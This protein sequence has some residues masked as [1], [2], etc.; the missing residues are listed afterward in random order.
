MSKAFFYYFPKLFFIDLFFFK[1]FTKE[2]AEQWRGL[3]QDSGDPIEFGKKAIRFYKKH[4]INPKE[5][6]IIFSDGLDIKKIYKIEKA[7]KGKIKTA[8]GWG[9]NLTNDVGAKPI[10]IVVKAVEANGRPLVKLSD[11]LAK[12]LGNPKTIE[13]DKKAFGYESTYEEPVYY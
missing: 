2:K 7:F 5:K 4:G 13:K 9:T 8:Y 11:N 3:R 1:D 12:A 10:S 6:L